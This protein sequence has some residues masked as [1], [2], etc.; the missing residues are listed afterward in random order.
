[1]TVPTAIR[2]AALIVTLAIVSMVACAEDNV[3][4]HRSISVSGQGEA[5]GAPDQAS[6]N[7]GVQTRADTVIEAASENQAIVEK[8]MSAL[9]QQGIDDKDIQTSN[10]SI[11]PEQRSDPRGSG[12]ISI[13]AYRVSNTVNIVVKDI[14]NVGEVL[15]AVTNAGANTVNGI[16]FSVQDPSELERQARAAAMNN[17]R[18]RAEDLA[19]LA[20]VKLGDVLTVSMSSGGGGPVPMMANARFAMAESAPAPSVSPGELSVSVQVRVTY[21]IE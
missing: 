19:R 18:E 9:E 8:I 13:V 17:A 20:G 14:D 7:V 2:S 16:N 11:Y 3:S 15:G 6:V 1:M 12:E 4:N 5:S 21:G 10:Y